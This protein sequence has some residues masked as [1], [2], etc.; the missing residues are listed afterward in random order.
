ME[1]QK[2]HSLFNIFLAVSI[3]S[4]LAVILL[5][6]T[7]S[8]AKSGI[9][10]VAMFA[11]MALYARGTR[12][13]RGSSFTFWVFTFLAAAMYFPWLF[14]NWGFNTKRLVVPLIQLIMFG[15]GTKLSVGDFVREFK[16]PKALIVGTFLI[17]A[18]MPLAGFVVAKVFR[19]EP[20]IA[21][22][23]ILI[24]S[25]PGGVASNVMAYLANGNIALSVSLTAFA[26]LVSPI[27]TPLLMKI[28]AGRLID[29][30]FFGMMISILK[31]II[32]PIAA[33]LI[34]N[35]I[36]HGRKRWFDRILP[37]LS[38]TAILFFVTIVVAHYR[39]ELLVV[40]LALLGA[41]IV[42]N[43]I[44]YVLGYW[45]ARAAGLSET[46]CRTI[47][48]EV[49]L[50]NGGMGMGLALDVLKSPDA[51]F[52]PIIFGKWMNISGSALANFWR[53]KPVKSEESK[54]AEA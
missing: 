26:T 18:I 54:G 2:N 32:L 17:F 12:V 14:T 52:A 16:R 8:G 43:F 48:I 47:S 11:S 30:A 1:G 34:V 27:V 38:M 23:V 44:G 13:L 15:M 42:H 50:K 46:D 41:A 45:A 36:L 22:G 25:C 29:I 9:P 19:F 3:L 5:V 31:M 21:A 37:L 49:G 24:G 40:G 53:Q 39:D 35:K 4:L 6:A 7:G 28:F 51:A 33:G 10:F 20:E